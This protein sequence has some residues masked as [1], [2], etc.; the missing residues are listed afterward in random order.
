[1]HAGWRPC[2]RHDRAHGAL[3]RVRPHRQVDRPGAPSIRRVIAACKASGK[4]A[5]IGGDKDLVRQAQLVSEGI[6][7]VTPQSDIAF[8]MA[9]AAR[10]NDDRVAYRFVKAVLASSGMTSIDDAVFDDARRAFGEAGIVDLAGLVGYYT[11]LAMVLNTFEVRPE[12][13]GIP[14]RQPNGQA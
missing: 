4:W 3:G 1:V 9:E 12:N 13:A 10:R 7:L 14:W 8:L 5:E 2:A 6:R 11:L